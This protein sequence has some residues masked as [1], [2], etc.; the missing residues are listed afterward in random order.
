[1][2]TPSAPFPSEAIPAASITGLV[3]AGGRGLRMGG[4]DKGLQMLHGRPLVAH[5]LE[6]LAPQTGALAISANRNEHAYEALGAPWHATIVADS[7]PDFPG[8]LAGL[9]AGLHAAQT[10]WLLAVPCDS[11]YLGDDLAA[12]LGRAALA[13]HADIATVL[14]P[15][16]A[17]EMSL[18]PVFV[19]LRTSLAADLAAF[20][21]AGER[22]VRA[23]YARHKTVEVP[24][25][26]GRAF[27]NINSLQELAAQDRA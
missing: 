1:M 21:G 17:G 22:K 26:D 18:H 4:A 23:W 10:D 27:Y 16:P 9:L 5:V 3:L 8:P 20:L 7:L 6:R 14:A 12:V 11:P 25:A 2:T 13:Q 19:L 15:D 24:F